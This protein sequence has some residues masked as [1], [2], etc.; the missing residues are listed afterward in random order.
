MRCSAPTVLGGFLTPVGGTTANTTAGSTL[1]VS[2]NGV[3]TYQFVVGAGSGTYQLQVDYPY[4][5]TNY[6]G[7]IQ[8][9]AYKIADGAT[10]LNDVLKGIVSLIASINK[11]IAALAKLVAKK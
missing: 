4:L 1:D 10:S 11:Q 2:S 6:S 5:D 7:S 3:I 9:V 8:T